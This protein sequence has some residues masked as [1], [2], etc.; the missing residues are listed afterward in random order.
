MRSR[1]LA[2]LI[3][4][5]SAI[6]SLKL[7]LVVLIR[8]SKLSFI[9]AHALTISSL[10]AFTLQAAACNRMSRHQRISLCPKRYVRDNEIYPLYAEDTEVLGSLCHHIHHL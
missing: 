10:E 8:V 7:F 6:S 1:F 4:R 9:S 2:S 3:N 5:S